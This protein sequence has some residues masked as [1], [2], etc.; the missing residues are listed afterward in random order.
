L[1]AS[2]SLFLPVLDAFMEGHP[3]VLKLAVLNDTN[4]F[5]LKRESRRVVR[6]EFVFDGASE[7]FAFGQ[8]VV[9]FAMCLADTFA[10]LKLPDEVLEP[11]QQRR[12]AILSQG[13][14]KKD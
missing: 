4:Q 10:T 12:M 3:N 14:E 2:V 9:E 8:D 11:I 1:G 7:E 13:K 6:L 5:D